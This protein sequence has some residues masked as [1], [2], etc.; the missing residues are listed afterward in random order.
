MSRE[1]L[2]AI[3]DRHLPGSAA[4]DRAAAADAVLRVLGDWED[5][6]GRADLDGRFAV[7]CADVAYV[8]DQVLRGAELRVLRRRT[9]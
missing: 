5:V 7:E 9:A 6:T 1:D 2:L 3:L 8:A 4:T